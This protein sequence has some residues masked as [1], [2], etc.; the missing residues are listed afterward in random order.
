MII[1]IPLQIDEQKMEEVVARDYEGKILNEI[2]KY[3][4]STL[5]K[6]AQNYYGDYNDKML[7][8]MQYLIEARIEKYLADYKDEIIEH[9]SKILAER[10]ARSK[11]GKEILENLT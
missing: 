11:K 8:G 4:K 3:I 6:K 7:D 9:A 10:L 1:N 2:T 5:V